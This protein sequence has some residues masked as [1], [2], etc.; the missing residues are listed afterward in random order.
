MELRRKHGWALWFTQALL[1]P[2]LYFLVWGPVE[3]VMRGHY[4]SQPANVFHSLFAPLSWLYR[5]RDVFRTLTDCYFN[6]LR[7][8]FP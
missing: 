4:D 2:G 3:F 5:H 7:P 1:M 8:H 6:L